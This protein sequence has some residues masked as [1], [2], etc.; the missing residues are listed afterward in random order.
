[1]Q[2]LVDL[3]IS[4]NT[5]GPITSECLSNYL[6]NPQCVLER[7]ALRHADVD[8]GECEG[9]VMSL[10]TNSSLVTLDLSENLIGSAENLNTVMPDFVTG[11]EALADLLRSENCHL[12][13]L[14]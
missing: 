5:L 12:K 9:F 11:S 2:G 14:W 3:D 1:M 7:L 6:A 13:T 8:D 4:F 10:K